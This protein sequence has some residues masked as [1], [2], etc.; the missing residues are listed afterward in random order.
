[1]DITR[2][3]FAGSNTAYGFQ[4]YFDSIINIAD[5]ERVY[6]LKG[7]PGVGKSGLMKRIGQYAKEL[8]YELV[9]YHC[10]SDPDS[11]DA[12]TIPAL[13][14]AL[15]DG[16]APHTVDPRF[17]GAV[18]EI[19][20]LGEFLSTPALIGRREEIF[21]V[22]TRISGRFN[23]AYCYT[24]AAESMR[25]AAS[26]DLRWN[27]AKTNQLLMQ[28]FE[29]L[30]AYG[31][32][33]EPFGRVKDLYLSAITPDGIVD[34]TS[35]AVRKT[36]W[37]VLAPW[38]ADIT[39]WLDRY[40]EVAIMQG[41]DVMRCHDPLNPKRLSHLIVDSSLLITTSTKSGIAEFDADWETDLYPYIIQ[42]DSEKGRDDKAA[43]DS[44]LAGAVE[45]LAEAKRLHDELERPYAE[46]MNFKEVDAVREKLKHQIFHR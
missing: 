33:A 41:M 40:C 13:K 10:S 34:F 42:G 12:L 25:T 26:L 11:L 4:G 38:Y 6:I 20:N 31:S 3:F 17:P 24:L 21:D 35:D 27:T 18:D 15:M 2:R 1:M 45:S 46:A 5:V 36:V 16:T 9:Y 39:S 19:I 37:R 14:I 28:M 29:E 30:N 23:R 32:A 8:G 22:Q 7:G 44:L 43:Y